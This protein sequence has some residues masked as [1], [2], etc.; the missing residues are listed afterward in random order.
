MPRES[1]QSVKYMVQTSSSACVCLRLLIGMR[2]CLLPRCS[3]D[4]L[5]R[6]DMLMC[7]LCV[8]NIWC[9]VVLYAQRH[10]LH[11]LPS[12]TNCRGMTLC[13]SARPQS[14]LCPM[15]RLDGSAA[16][17]GSTT[18][19]S[20]LQCLQCWVPAIGLLERMRL[21]RQM[22][23]VMGCCFQPCRQRSG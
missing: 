23:R 18:P 2:G 8:A 14:S 5:L 4:S 11:Q 17:T 13:Q 20:R 16:R 15:D 22:L 19:A 9:Y 1:W 6:A 12:R 10:S 21:Q 7:A 3:R